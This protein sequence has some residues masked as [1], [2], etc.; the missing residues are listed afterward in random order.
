M[1]ENFEP[2][3]PAD[4]PSLCINK[5]TLKLEGDYVQ[6][7]T[8][9]AFITYLNKDANALTEIEFIYTF[10]TSTNNYFPLLPVADTEP[11]YEVNN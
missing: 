9:I 4:I 11:P 2:L 10:K 8:I 7:C 3:N 1:H 6:N 5:R